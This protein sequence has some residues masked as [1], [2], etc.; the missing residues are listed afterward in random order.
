[1]TEKVSA[2]SF[3]KRIGSQISFLFNKCTDSMF[4]V[5]SSL[6]VDSEDAKKI[7]VATGRP[8][9]VYELAKDASERAHWIDSDSN[10]SPIDVFESG[11][12]NSWVYEFNQLKNSNRRLKESLSFLNMKEKALSP[13]ES[14]PAFSSPE[15]IASDETNLF[16]ADRFEGC[17]GS[18][19]SDHGFRDQVSS[20]NPKKRKNVEDFSSDQ[21][22]KKTSM[23][24]LFF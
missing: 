4:L 6:T 2:S 20:P 12:S 13:P 24:P 9:P 10:S 11:S 14:L 8:R 21:V 22:F 7:V 18:P 17:F 3:L 15:S 23:S 5:L 16:D 19:P 1:V